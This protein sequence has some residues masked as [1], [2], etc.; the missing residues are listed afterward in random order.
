MVTYTSVLTLAES[1]PY[2]QGETLH[3][4][5]KVTAS[6][7]SAPFGDFYLYVTPSVPGW[8]TGTILTQFPGYAQAEITQ[9]LNF[10]PTASPDGYAFYA[11]YYSTITDQYYF[12]NYIYLNFATLTLAVEESPPYSC[13][14]TIHAIVT[15]YDSTVLPLV[16]GTVEVYNSANSSFSIPPVIGT[17]V[18][19]PGDGYSQVIIPITLVES[20]FQSDVF[21][22]TGN[23]NS[24]NLPVSGTFVPP[25]IPIA[26][27]RLYPTTTTITSFSASLGSNGT[28]TPASS[29]ENNY[30]FTVVVASSS[31]TPTG[32]VTLFQSGYPIASNVPLV[33]G[34]ATITF[35]FFG[36]A[37]DYYYQAEYLPGTSCYQPSVS[38][39]SAA[40]YGVIHAIPLWAPL[41]VIT[42]Y[43]QVV[44]L[45]TGQ[46]IVLTA[47]WYRNGNFGNMTGQYTFSAAVLPS[48][49]FANGSIV[50][51][52]VPY[53]LTGTP[54]VINITD[55][56]VPGGGPDPITIRFTSN[57]AAVGGGDTTIST[58]SVNYSGNNFSGSFFGGSAV[59]SSLFQYSNGGS[60]GST[61]PY[62]PF[63]Y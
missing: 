25:I 41:C 7:G 4:T 24:I 8:G 20:S 31:G 58:F 60:F 35:G 13:G 27:P 42:E 55:P 1:P 48:G 37:G 34:V 51:C 47:S 22:L 56:G 36:A 44:D 10:D 14:E 5:L 33:S 9:T 52:N 30:T 6:D 19:D 61:G 15:A 17:L 16:T 21:Q 63:V 26:I 38:V 12:A 2:H 40:P 53:T 3:F 11:D 45:V 18:A 28:Y 32:T 29:S 23:F 54:G 46:T 50:S 39:H 49:Q 57:M 59:V 62:L 43:P